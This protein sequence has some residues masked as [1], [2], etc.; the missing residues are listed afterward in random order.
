MKRQRCKIT[1]WKGRNSA[2]IHKE[3]TFKLP[4]KNSNIIICNHPPS[5]LCNQ[6][7]T[8]FPSLPLTSD[9]QYFPHQFAQLEAQT[10]CEKRKEIVNVNIKP[11]TTRSQARISLHASSPPSSSS[12]PGRQPNFLCFRLPILLPSLSRSVTVLTLLGRK[13]IR[14]NLNNKLVCF[15][16]LHSSK[17]LFNTLDG[18]YKLILSFSLVSV[19]LDN[20]T[21]YEFLHHK[22]LRFAL[23]FSLIESSPT[24]LPLYKFECDNKVTSE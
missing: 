2:N 17:P 12:S 24:S 4:L 7:L 8:Y 19:S 22:L 5:P 13:K 6:N 18:C 20:S 14:H 16:Q 23:H 15:K 3:I 11:W 1:P 21:I 10:I 9:C